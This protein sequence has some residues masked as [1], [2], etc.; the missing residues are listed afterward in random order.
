MKELIKSIIF[1][2]IMTLLQLLTVLIITT[3]YYPFYSGKDYFKSNTFETI[4]LIST[5]I[6]TLIMILVLKKKIKLEK[7][8][9]K[10]ALLSIII[11]ITLSIIMYLINNKTSDTNLLIL[12][13]TGI[14]A[15]ILEEFMYR[16]IIYSN[17]SKHK[18]IFT[19]LLFILSHPISKIP[20]AT[21]L[22]IVLIFSLKK[23][24]S[25][26]SPILIHISANITSLIL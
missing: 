9:K 14:L 25:I 1:I 15:P 13:E 10:Q 20:F 11:G 3:I 12:F 7:I 23:T 21:I 4:A 24:K 19:T 5:I 16:G 2:I 8:T 17:L 6:Y 18:E 22:G 26:R